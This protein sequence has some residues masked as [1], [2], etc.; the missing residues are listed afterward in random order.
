MSDNI[1]VKIILDD[2]FSSGMKTMIEQIKKFKK[3]ISDLTTDL[4]KLSKKKIEL[5][6]NT[7][8]FSKNIKSANNDVKGLNSTLDNLYKSKNKKN[9]YD[10]AI[11]QIGTK[12]KKSQKNVDNLA[13]SVSKLDNDI[14]SRVDIGSGKK[15][16]KSSGSMWSVVGNQIK[17][18]AMEIASLYLPESI[19]STLSGVIEGA[20]SGFTLTGGNPVGAVVGAIAKGGSNYLLSEANQKVEKQQQRIQFGSNMIQQYIPQL[21]MS[22]INY[23]SGLEQ[24]ELQ[25]QRKNGINDSKGM[26]SNIQDFSR[27]TPL[28]FSESVGL[29]NNMLSSGFEQ[30]DISNSF[31]SI[32]NVASGLNLGKEEIYSITEA[33][34]KMKSSGKMTIEE[35]NPLIERNIDVWGILSKGTSKTRAE[36]INLA[37][38][39]ALPAEQNLEKL[40]KGMGKIPNEVDKQS[41]SFEGLISNL[42]EGASQ[43]LLGP[44]GSGFIE[45]I[46]PALEGFATFFGFGTEGFNDLKNDIEIFGQQIGSFLGTA[47]GGIQETLGGLLNSDKFKDASLPEKFLMVLGEL[48]GKADEWY[49]D[50]GQKL[51]ESVKGFFVEMFAKLSSDD[52]FLNAIQDLWLTISPNAETVRKILLKAAG[53]DWV[54]KHTLSDKEIKERGQYKAIGIDRVPY[55]GYRA[56]LHEGERVLTRVQADNQTGSISINKIAD[57]LIVREETDI[58]KITQ[59]LITKLESYRLSY[60]GAC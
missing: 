54:N 11:E 29:T 48:Q 40:I 39:G 44:L 59:N 36:L 55:D 17:E 2:K 53:L 37:T 33:L 15:T 35:L 43:L 31:K 38:K 57:T 13:N 58:D 19:S 9:S 24:T 41:Q 26:I 28:D 30:N 18:P 60:G 7:D 52:E 16:Q 4:D 8:K 20:I 12:A 23:A 56:I 5:K 42:K 22:S 45:G 47:I 51:I 3:E 34:G 46:K 6:L 27:N 14:N 32:G 21:A 49:A 50:G 25:L 10:N 1:S